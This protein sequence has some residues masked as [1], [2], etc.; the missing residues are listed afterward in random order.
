MNFQIMHMQSSIQQRMQNRH[1]VI[2]AEHTQQVLE[3]S[4]RPDT[5]FVCSTHPHC[6]QETSRRRKS[7]RT[8]MWSTLFKLSHFN[9]PRA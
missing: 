5:S 6:L 4:P 3:V 2:G 9:D 7:R 1:L 8:A